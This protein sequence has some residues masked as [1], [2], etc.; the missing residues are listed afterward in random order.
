MS[1]GAL[2][3]QVGHVLGRG[4]ALFGEPPVSGG[5][6]AGDAG[7]RLGAAG[8]V[9][10][11]GQQR[12]RGLSGAVPV[13]YT[14]FASN[15][16][17]ALDAAAG[18]DIRLSH[19]LRDSAEADRRGRQSSASVL[20]GAASDTAKLAP[21]ARTP[22]GQRALITALHTRL[23]Q[24]RQVIDAYEMRSAR[25]AALVRALRYGQARPGG[26]MP[27]GATPF[28]G[29]GG[30]RPGGGGGLPTGGLSG[31]GA[32]VTALVGRVTPQS[33]ANPATAGL[34]PS[35]G[36]V[37]TSLGALTVHSSPRD[38]AAAIIH[39]AQRRGYSPYQATAILADAMQESHL[40]P[41]AKNP[42]GLW[43]SIF[44]QDASY[45][46][47]RDPNLAIAEFLNR[48]AKHGGP[49]SPDIWK[50][51]FWLQQR[52]GDPSAE[53]A[54]ARG[55]PAYLSEIQSQ[56]RAAVALYREIATA[57]VL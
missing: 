39:E 43:E 5:G 54:Y 26:G 47:R 25:M 10:R 11:T 16:G 44:Q 27:A 55:R 36:T 37:G 33:Q 22:A 6:A 23:A 29:T 53:A 48:L 52:P 15:A 2:V 35:G 31:W 57:T 40:D 20:H 51:I 8:D 24:Q 56:H 4:H 49:A 21:A 18:I 30:G 45:P 42:N 3:Q 1:V 17:P 7:S 32:P 14:R 41:R 9:V 50:S 12:I 38:V 28:D 19:R 34:W 13:G 46:G